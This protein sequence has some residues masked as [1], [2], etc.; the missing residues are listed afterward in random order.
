LLQTNP[1]NTPIA[2]ARVAAIL[3]AAML[4]LFTERIAA[5][6]PSAAEGYEDSPLNLHEWLVTRPAA[7]FFYRVRGDALRSECIRDGSI[8]VVDRSLKPSPGQLIVAEDAGEFVIC[9]FNASASG[10][11]LPVLCVGVITAVVTRFTACTR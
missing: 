10:H 8:L 3:A 7:T 5:G 1:F 6:F 4:L 9:R 11:R 2:P